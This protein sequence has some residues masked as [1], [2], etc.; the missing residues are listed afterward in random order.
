MSSL[1]F[2]EDPLYNFPGPLTDDDYEKFQKFLTCLSTQ[3][4]KMDKIRQNAI[5]KTKKGQVLYE[6]LM[7]IIKTIKSEGGFLNQIRPELLMSYDDYLEII[8]FKD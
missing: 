3:Y 1:G 7:T 5:K 6:Y 4:E 2:V 8:R